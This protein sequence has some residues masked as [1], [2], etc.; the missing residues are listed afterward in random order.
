MLVVADTSPLRY[1]IAIGEEGVLPTIF[2]EVWVPGAVVAELTTSSTPESV[3]HLMENRPRWLSVRDPQEA[4]V[5]GV[6][7]DLDPGER[8][9]LAL[10][11]ELRAD[12][13]LLDDAAGRREA[14]SLGLRM[15][16]TVGVLRLA[17][18][19]RLI[20]VRPVLARLRASGFY[21]H[22]S[23]IHAAFENWL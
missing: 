7:P 16:G 6:N 19:R 17:A 2:G 10:A 23:V 20:D 15:T 22:E 21:I 8:A 18:E 1:L 9:A 13:V 11:L 5:A 12:L 3:R 4:A 14:A